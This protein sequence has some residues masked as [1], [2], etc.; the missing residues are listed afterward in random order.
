M[1]RYREKLR[2]VS[3]RRPDLR[4][5]AV[6]SLL[7]L[8]V[9]LIPLIRMTVYA[10][11]WYDGYNFGRYVKNFLEEEYS[12]RSA[13]RGAAVCVKSEYYAWQGSYTATFFSALM[14]AVWGEEFYFLGPLFI[15]LILPVSVCVLMKTLMRDVL[16][17]DMA[18][19]VIVQSVAAAIAVV[20]IH[21]PQEGFYWY[22]GGS[23]YVGVHSFL[24]LL[25]AAWIKLLTGRRKASAAA[26]L[27]G[28]MA[29]AALVAGSTYV[30]ALQ[31][32]LIGL[33]IAALGALLRNK[34]ALLLIPS[35]LIYAYGFYMS[36]SAW[37]NQVRKAVLAES[38]MGM[39]AVSAIAASFMEA[40]RHMA[41]FTD[42]MMLI[43]MIFLAPVI[44]NMVRKSSF[45]FRYPGMLL[46]WSFCLYAAGFTPC[47]YSL[48]Y[49]GPERALNVMKLTYQML[50]LLNEGYW[51]GWLY[52]KLR[53]AGEITLFGWQWEKKKE[54]S[55]S[56]K[57]A[58]VIFYMTIVLLA[59]SVGIVEPDKE[60]SY[61]S[62][63]AYHY[64]H[65]GEAYNFHQEYLKRVE[66]IKNGGDVVVVEPYHF[67]PWII[68]MGELSEDADSGPNSAIAHFYDKQ[69]VMVR[70]Q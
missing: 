45:Q 25:T 14:P 68:F 42:M 61:S 51:L 5:V 56:G 15:I 9:L 49:A 22:V 50:L 27:I 53:Q 29:G 16:K 66:A 46:L 10:V 32:I 12:L 64:V 19:C 38:G 28:T 54:I 62:Y 26:L 24:M 59:L 40:F 13:L 34:R 7:A 41:E 33:S 11:P 36:A 43:M 44:W 31:G 58:P 21:S 67:K 37:G 6:F 60:G 39:D 52:G 65:T 2:R 57:N 55:A 3:L 17:A 30:T 23:C 20:L 1:H 18:S 63:C 8:I 47:L 4:L 48:G 69:A 35:L 70:K